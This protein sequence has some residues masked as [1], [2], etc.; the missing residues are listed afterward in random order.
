MRLVAGVARRTAGLR[1]P[2]PWVFPRL[3]SEPGK[4]PQ[5]S[6]RAPDGAKFSPRYPHSR[7]RYHHPQTARAVSFR[8]R[9]PGRLPPRDPPDRG[10][11]APRNCG[12]SA[13]TLTT[14]VTKR[15]FVPS[16]P[17]ERHSWVVVKVAPVQNRKS[18]TERYRQ[19]AER[20]WPGAI[21]DI[22][23]QLPL[24]RR[25]NTQ[26]RALLSKIW[27]GPPQRWRMAI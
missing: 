23:F 25:M 16:R 27:P 6:P 5:P 9:A 7:N 22:Q 3:R 20:K 2:P 19:N 4:I 12:R 14:A 18:T 10:W 1:E 26:C 11:N 13:T 21:A 8:P 17:C 15:F 24:A